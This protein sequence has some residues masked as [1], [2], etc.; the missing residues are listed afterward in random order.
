MQINNKVLTIFAVLGVMV[1]LWGVPA[2]AAGDK[3]DK[4][5]VGGKSATI[6]ELDNL[7]NRIK[8]LEKKLKVRKLEKEMEETVSEE[9]EMSFPTSAQKILSSRSGVRKVKDLMKKLPRGL[10]TSSRPDLDL[11]KKK[12]GKSEE[13]L[14][15]VEK[16]EEKEQFRKDISK[17]RVTAVSGFGDNIQARIRLVGGGVLTV[18][19]GQSYNRLGTVTDI[20]LDKVVLEKF[21]EKFFIPYSRIPERP[22][23]PGSPESSERPQPGRP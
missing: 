12:K 21:G 9:D 2:N 10:I 15:E 22:R 11:G 7:D 1:Y 18:E 19:T 3:T 20:S 4:P 8:V 6:E 17:A 16:K 13:Y 23:S 5:A 14:K